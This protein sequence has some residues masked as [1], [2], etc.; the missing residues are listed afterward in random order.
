M[1]AFATQKNIQTT[2]ASVV[3]IGANGAGRSK[4]LSAAELRAAAEAYSSAQVD[5]LLSGKVGTGDSRLSDARTPTAH[6]ST[7]VSGG[8]DAFT[9]AEIR[10]ILGVSTLSGSN[11]GDQDLSSYLT[12]S[13]AAGLYL[14]LAGGTLTGPITGTSDIIEQRRGLNAQTYDLFETFTSGT[15][16]GSLRL[17]AGSS[18][19][20]IG[21]AI[22]SAGGT[23]RALQLGTYNSAGAFTAGLT[24]ATNGTVSTGSVFCANGSG[25]GFEGGSAVNISNG[26]GL[27]T[28]RSITGGA[29]TRF[30][31]GNGSTEWMRINNGGQLVINTTTVVDGA[32]LTVNGGIASAGNF[33]CVPSAS[34]TLAAN[35]QFSVEM[36]S[37][38]AGNLVY[39]GSDGTTRR[40]AMTFA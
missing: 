5:A 2:G 28:I 16:F 12:S 13:A 30:M 29:G 22:G 3:P 27:L 14:P 9:A 35:G 39:R 40:F 25:I 23:N 33:I 24:V 4:L 17:R 21:S 34:R 31:A 19:H 7:H 20:Q 10:T 18:G 32:L 37:N 26:G 1:T 15:N 36:T 11:T 38:T 6:K 8:S